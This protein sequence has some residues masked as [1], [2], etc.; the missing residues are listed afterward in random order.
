VIIYCALDENRIRFDNLEP[1]IV[2]DLPLTNPPKRRPGRI[3]RMYIRTPQYSATW[4]HINGR[5]EIGISRPESISG[6]FLFFDVRS[7]GL[8]AWN[9]LTDK[10]GSKVA[11][12]IAKVKK[13]AGAVTIDTSDPKYVQL[14][15]LAGLAT[16]GSQELRYWLRPDQAFAPVKLKLRTRRINSPDEDWQLI[17]RAETSW[18][19]I[20]GVWVPVELE[21][22]WN[23]EGTEEKLAGKIRWLSVNKEIDDKRFD[24]ED[25]GAPDTIP[26]VDTTT[27]QAVVIRP[28]LTVTEWMAQPRPKP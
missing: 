13:V 12:T 18:E 25:F 6:Q 2:A 7:L 14:V 24:W 21:M 4:D 10:K 27:G 11:A 15:L 8:M 23:R 19:Q 16:G 26:V 3:E 20:A 5:S 17:E 1:G 22:S 28:G 9:Q